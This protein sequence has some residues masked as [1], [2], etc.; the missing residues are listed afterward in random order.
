[1]DNVK[2]QD[3]LKAHCFVV[4][5]DRCTDRMELCKK[6]IASAGFTNVHRFRG[7]DATTDDLD[8]AWRVHGSPKFD[9]NDTEFVT[10]YKGKQGCALS[11]YGVWKEMIDKNIPYAVVFEDDVE[12]HSEWN[13]LSEPYWNATPKDFDILYMGSQIDMM[14]NGNI[15]V[16][17]VFCTHAYVVTLEG[18]KKLYDICVN[19]PS[20]TRTIDCILI[21]RMKEAFASG[22]RVLP[23][24]WYVWNG[25]MFED[26][27]AVKQ[28]SWAKRNTGLVFQDADLGTFVRPW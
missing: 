14:K 16:T 11:H 6:R 13:A 24:R 3:L 8:E 7:I 20:G 12:F 2:W 9:E 21:D 15:I 10:T 19:C 18:A 26:K 28:P 25:T 1:M 17:P 22:G 23:F 27:S 4:N 5:M